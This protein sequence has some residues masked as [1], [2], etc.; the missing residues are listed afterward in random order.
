[1]KKLLD[2]SSVEQPPFPPLG[3][4]LEFMRLLWAVDHGLQ[5][6]SKRME[7]TLGV[8]SP[9]RLVMRILVRFPS[10]TAGQLAAILY[11][12]PSTLTGILKRLEKQG[13]VNRRTSPHDHRRVLL[14]LTARG[15]QKLEL[16]N[17][18]TVENAVRTALT[19]LPD[20]KLRSAADVLS[21][22]A[23]VLDE[24]LRESS[25]TNP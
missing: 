12:H 4:A 5:R 24:I 23:S 7:T 20:A 15:K 16:D 17:E 25:V 14:G 10:I 13:F 22:L 8:T 9:Q 11:I 3:D 2:L 18:G 21:K 6:L 1:M 19:E